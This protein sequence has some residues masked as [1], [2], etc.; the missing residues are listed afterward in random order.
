MPKLPFQLDRV[1]IGGLKLAGGI[2]LGFYGMPLIE[3]VMPKDITTKYRKYFG[4][5]HV[6]VGAVAAA[7]IRKQLV[8]DLALTVAGVGVYD[9]IASNLPMLGLPPIQA[10]LPSFQGDEPGVIGME[11]DFAPALGSSYQAMGASYGVD[12]IAYGGDTD[13]TDC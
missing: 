4:L 8:R 10:T 1:A 6:V 12:D 2:A 5:I 9:L 7:T 13:S 3:K 11:A